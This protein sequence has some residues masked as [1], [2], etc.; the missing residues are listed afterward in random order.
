L[1]GGTFENA[2][3]YVRAL[4]AAIRSETRHDGGALLVEV[5][6][7]GELSLVQQTLLR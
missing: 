3:E 4:Q 2:S 5:D 6:P 7:D 1:G